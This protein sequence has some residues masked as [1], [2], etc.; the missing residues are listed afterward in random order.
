MVKV[1]IAPTNK[2]PRPTPI[3]TTNACPIDNLGDRS[4]SRVRVRGEVHSLDQHERRSEAEHRPAHGERWGERLGSSRLRGRRGDV[5]REG[6]RAG[7]GPVA[8]ANP[9]DANGL[10][11]EK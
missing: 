6:G 5:C 9:S 10:E 8:G 7:E 11:G 2:T 1:H 4:S 3:V